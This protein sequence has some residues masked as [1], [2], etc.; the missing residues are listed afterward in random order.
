M[1]VWSTTRDWALQWREVGQRIAEAIEKNPTIQASWDEN[2]DFKLRNF[3]EAYVD[4]NGSVQAHP[5]P[6][7]LTN[8]LN[9]VPLN[10]DFLDEE[11]K[12]VWS[13]SLRSKQ[14]FTVV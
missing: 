2:T 8:S 4:E 10:E 6:F 11:V 1:K 14:T 9:E 3:G 5:S 7:V 12:R 13:S